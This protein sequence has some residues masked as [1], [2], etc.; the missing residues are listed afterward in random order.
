M[1]A[2]LC[3]ASLRSIPGIARVTPPRIV[4]VSAAI[5]IAALGVSGTL[6]ALFPARRAAML[7]PVEALRKE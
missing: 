2:L 7:T 4:P 1:T 5:A 6:A 3:R